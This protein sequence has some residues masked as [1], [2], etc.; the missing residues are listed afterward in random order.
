M[1]EELYD[2]LE[3]KSTPLYIFDIDEFANR[4]KRIKEIVGNDIEICYSIKANPFLLYEFPS[5]FKHIEVCSPGELSICEKNKVDMSRIIY[6][7]V[8]KGYEDVER[9]I[10]DNVGIV[11]AESVRHVNII[12]EIAMKKNKC[13]PVLLRLTSGS[14][15]G[16]DE[17]E[18]ASIIKTRQ[19]FSGINIIGLHYFSGTQKK[20]SKTIEKEL[21]YIDRFIDYIYKEYDFKLEYIEYG[22]GLAVDYYV[23]NVDSIGFERLEETSNLLKKFAQKH[24]LTIEMGRFFAASCG[25]YYSKVI[26]CKTNCEVNYAIL[27]GG[28]NHIK[29]YGQYQGMQIPAIN[30][31]NLT[32][33]ANESI[34]Q[35]WTVCGSLCTTADVLIANIMLVSLEIGDVIAFKNVGAYSVTEGMSLFLSR[36]L[37]RI[38]LYSKTNGFKKVRSQIPSYV[39]NMQMI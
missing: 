24:H 16:M 23:E 32:N 20:K 15:F 4:A 19:K 5:V 31:I 28:L 1:K 34:M 9:A 8:N 37:P 26:D 6:S 38:L 30:H 33:K 10:D 18:F 25:T 2:I 7:G 29:Y 39:F 3:N 22:P 27:D 36:D 35:P 12:N 11:T 17:K 14:Q 13:V 21:Q